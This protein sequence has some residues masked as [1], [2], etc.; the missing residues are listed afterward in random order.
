[1][2]LDGRHPHFDD[3]R[4]IHWHLRLADA[5]PLARAAGKRVFVCYGG[6]A[7]AGTRA[8]IE[9]TLW[10][11]EIAEFL[12]G[13]FVSV[14]S[15]AAGGD[16]DADALVVG[17]PKREPTPLCIYVTAD[18]RAVHSTA[19]ARPPAVLLTDMLEALNRK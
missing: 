19:G 7:C 13:H 4:A 9:R 16:A 2:A 3:R 17:L 12:N 15:E 8:L 1:M 5:L 10:K 18:G 6:K 11:E 14:A